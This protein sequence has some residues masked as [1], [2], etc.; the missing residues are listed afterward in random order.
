MCNTEQ[1]KLHQQPEGKQQTL[2]LKCTWK[3]KKRG[4]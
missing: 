3:G 2:L 4:S 1:G